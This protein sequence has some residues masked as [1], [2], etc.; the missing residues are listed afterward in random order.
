MEAELS[1]RIRKWALTLTGRQ[2]LAVEKFAD[3][4]EVIPWTLAESCGLNPRD[5]MLEIRS[6]HAKGKKWFGVDVRNR[7]LADMQNKGIYDIFAVKSRVLDTATEVAALTL[8]ID[9]VLTRPKWNPPR[10]PE[11]PAAH[12]VTP[13]QRV[14]GFEYGEAKQFLPETW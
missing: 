10:I 12:R 4:L 2:Q 1:Y 14:P 11:G 5:S 8:R 7:R 6:E 13:V 3:A 9:T